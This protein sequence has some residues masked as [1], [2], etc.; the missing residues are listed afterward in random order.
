MPQ[1]EIDRSCLQGAGD[2]WVG[3]VNKYYL[4]S[5]SKCINEDSCCKFDDLSK[6]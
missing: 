1:K 5:I 2:D 4:E 6:D 3:K